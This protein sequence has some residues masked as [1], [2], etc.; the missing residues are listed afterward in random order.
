MREI[1]RAMIFH[2]QIDWVIYTP[3]AFID[4]KEFLPV[5][6]ILIRCKPEKLPGPKSTM[7]FFNGRVAVPR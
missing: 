3:K 5:P 1:N 6:E 2:V 7:A 4:E